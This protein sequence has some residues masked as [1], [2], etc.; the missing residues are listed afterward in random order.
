[1][2]LEVTI[3]E[4]TEDDLASTLELIAKQV[5]DGFTTGFDRSDSGGYRYTVT[6]EAEE[7]PED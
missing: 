1:M 6:G 7:Q 5:A 4:T 2:Q 3:E